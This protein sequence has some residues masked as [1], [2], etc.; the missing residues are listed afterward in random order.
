MILTILIVLRVA[1]GT[2]KGRAYNEWPED[3]VAKEPGEDVSW[4]NGSTD[5]E[6][7][8]NIRGNSLSNMMVSQSIVS[9]IQEGMCNGTTGDHTLVVSKH[10]GFSI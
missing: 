7:P 3:T 10:V 8:D 2:R 1:H 5:V 6:K 9:F 4:V